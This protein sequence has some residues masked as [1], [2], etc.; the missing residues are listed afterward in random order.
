[1]SFEPVDGAACYPQIHL[2]VLQYLLMFAVFS[3]E[4]RALHLCLLQV[5][6]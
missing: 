2:R 3:F 5:N 4:G 6:L 1:M